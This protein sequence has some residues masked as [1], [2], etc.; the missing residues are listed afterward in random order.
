M[1][2]GSRTFYRLSQSRARLNVHFPFEATTPA[3]PPVCTVIYSIV[4][5]TPWLRLGAFFGLVSRAV[6]N[7]L[8]RWRR[9]QTVREPRPTKVA[10]YYYFI[11]TM[12]SACSIRSTR[13]NGGRYEESVLFGSSRHGWLFVGSLGRT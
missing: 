9:V 3:E 6:R 8:R 7:R 13:D 4:R 2:R 10:L 1:G 5:G 11:L 12:K